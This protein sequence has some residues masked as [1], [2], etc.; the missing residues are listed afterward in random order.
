MRIHCLALVF[1]ASATLLAGCALQKK[2]EPISA[3]FLHGASPDSSIPR[4]PFKH[5]W[6]AERPSVQKVTAIYVLPVRTDRIAP[7]SWMESS[8]LSITS[9]EDY[10]EKVEALATFFHQRLTEELERVYS[11]NKRLRVVSKPAP[12][13]V[14]LELALTEVVFS[15]P[16]TN[17]AVMAAPVPGAG[18][19]LS[20]MTEPVIAFAGRFTSPDEGVLWGTVADRRNPPFRPI[21]LNKFTVASSARDVVSQ[22][23]REL[24]E[25]IEFDRLKPIERS[26]WFSLMPW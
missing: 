19:A 17:L 9:L 15:R 18:V 1:L 3:N 4:V 8:G 23:A 10:N 16:A 20:A 25:A 7:D 24:A 5:A 21:D 26:P 12:D 2:F 14:N 13:A 6:A 11:N 22:W